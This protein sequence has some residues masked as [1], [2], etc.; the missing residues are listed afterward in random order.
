MIG[1]SKLLIDADELKESFRWSEK[2]RLSIKEILAII[3]NAPIV[4]PERP[5][6]EWLTNR[7]AFHLTCPFCGCHIR[8]FKDMVFEGDYYYNFCPNCGADMRGERNE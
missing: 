5:K 6:G 2:C 4:E 3:D 8:A 1:M 7:V